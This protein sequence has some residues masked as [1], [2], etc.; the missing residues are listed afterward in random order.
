[1]LEFPFYRLLL[2]INAEP[3]SLNRSTLEVRPFSKDP[4]FSTESIIYVWTGRQN[5][6]KCVLFYSNQLC[7]GSVL[8]RCA[9]RLKRLS[10]GHGLG[11]SVVF[12]HVPKKPLLRGLTQPTYSLGLNFVFLLHRAV[13]VDLRPI[14]SIQL[15]YMIFCFVV[16]D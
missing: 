15:L 16:S 2:H 9:C 4:V 7:V 13:D 8:C 3:P 6:E 1:M 10:P 5:A 12:E 14:Y 11:Y